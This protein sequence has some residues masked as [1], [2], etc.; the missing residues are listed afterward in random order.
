MCA[1]D[2]RELLGINTVEQLAEAERIY[3]ELRRGD[4]GRIVSAAGA[5]RRRGRPRRMADAAASARARAPVGAVAHG[6]TIRSARRRRPGCL[7]CRVARSRATIARTWCWRAGRTRCSCSTASRTTRPTSWWRS[8]ATSARFDDADAP[9]E[10]ADLLELIALAERALGGGVS[11]A[12]HQLRRQ[13]RA[14]S[15]APASPATCTCTWCRAGT[16]TR[17]SCR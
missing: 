12:R 14:G 16:A 17:T 6:R 7:F 9:T 13:R 3:R 1:P 15:R 4:A 2:Y 10:R 8:R 5:G 11:S